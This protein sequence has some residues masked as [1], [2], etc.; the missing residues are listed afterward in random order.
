MGCTA[1]RG[2]R[3]GNFL[4]VPILGYFPWKTAA[5]FLR[6]AQRQAEAMQRFKRGL[7]HG[8]HKKTGMRQKDRIPVVF[9]SLFW[10]V[11]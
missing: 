9:C 2:K 8:Q 6:G 1:L 3:G 4:I 10:A 7:F 5:L 11:S